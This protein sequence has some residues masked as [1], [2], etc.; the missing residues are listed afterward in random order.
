MD[1]LRELHNLSDTELYNKYIEYN[2]N[3]YSSEDP[4]IKDKYKELIQEIRRILDDKELNSEQLKELHSR[5]YLS[6]PDYNN[7]EFNTDISRKLEFNINK[8][9]FNQQTTCGKQNFELG[10]HQ[11]LLYNFMNKN[12]PYKSLLIFHG[13]GVGKTCTA[14]KISESFRDI[15]TNKNNKIIVLRKGG[16]GQGWKNTIFDPNLGENQCSGHEFL[17]HINET[18]GFEKRDDQSIKRDVNK[19]IKKYYD[20]YAYREF[21]NSIDNML[22][23]C[24]K[25]E[26][27]E[28]II[29]KNNF[30]NRLLIVDEY[31]NLRSDESPDESSKGEKEEQKKA[32]KNLLKIVENADNLRL[33]LLTATPMYNTSDEIFNLLNIL[34]L[35]DNRPV[36]NYKQYITD[37]SINPDG[38]DILNRKFRGY[39]SYLRGENPVNF[40]IRIYPTD[41]PKSDK[42]PLGL[43]P[44]D[45]PKMDL[46]GK[47]IDTPMKFLITYDNK[48]HGDQKSAYEEL[49]SKLDDDRKLSIQDSNLKQ[50]CNV[51][52]PSKKN[53]YGKEGFESVFNESKKKF[54]YKKGVQHILEYK[55][56]HNHSIKIKNIIDNIK[57]SEGI[58]FIYSEYI[59]GGSVPVGLAL[60]HIGFNKYDNKNLLN[61]S[62]KGSEKGTY[63]ILS[64][65]ERVS[66]NN[67]EEIK[68]A[69]SEENKD[70]DLIKVIIG[71]SITG[72]GMDFKNIRQIHILDPWWHLSKLEQI[73]GRGIRYCSHIKLPE[74]KRNVTVFLHT[75]T[76]DGKETIDHYSYRLG[77][78]K[79]FEIGKVETILKKNAIDC[80]LFKDT[81]MI[82]DPKN[83]LKVDVKVSRNN[84]KKFK[85]S[86][87]DKPYSKICSYQPKC[88]YECDNIN[89][90][91]LDN[92]QDITDKTDINEYKK[93]MLVS[94]NYK[95][96]TWKG[97]I[98]GEGD[99]KNKVWVTTGK[100]DI[101]VPISKLTILNKIDDDTVNFDYF[102]DIKRN[103]LVY[104]NEL[105]NK[106][107]FFQ[108]HDIIE[109][110]Q[111]KKDIN[112]KIIYNILKNII[113]SKDRIYDEYNNQGYMICKNNI[114]IFQP[115][116]NNDENA[117]IFYRT[118]TGMN[119]KINIDIISGNMK[120]DLDK[121]IKKE[122][123]IKPNVKEISIKIK[124][125]YKEFLKDKILTRF[126]FVKDEY[127]E[128]LFNMCLDE[129]L[130]EEKQVLIKNVITNDHPKVIM[131]PGKL[132][133]EELLYLT[134]E[135]FKNHLIQKDDDERYT[136]FKYDRD[137]LGYIL[138]NKNILE[139]YDMDDNLID[140][141]LIERDLLKS[142]TELDKSEYDKIFNMN[143]LY[144]QPYINYN[145]NV[146]ERG[147]RYTFKFF[148][149]V[150]LGKG[151]IVG[152]DPGYTKTLVKRFMK[153]DISEF[154]YLKENIDEFFDNKTIY[155]EDKFKII[156]L[157]FRIKNIE[158]GRYVISDELNYLRLK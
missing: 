83:L 101:Q 20:F 19:L 79:S 40:P 71:S 44:K 124:E 4:V 129:L 16:L 48:L 1:D 65:D 138:M 12:T 152:N 132:K 53:K 105:Y 92:L 136:L 120:D 125:M 32:L 86:I 123:L 102:K 112:K 142:I 22:E 8:L 64:K 114:Y 63:V 49:I 75:A 140:K 99:K 58:I 29:I 90:K 158:N 67:N 72:E 11:R 135:Y 34:L 150:K 153:L 21:S 84:I 5:E 113:D 41:Y 96:E 151:V 82:K 9:Y 122:P 89:I 156:E 27:K 76:C 108:L 10:N 30:S 14:V 7:P 37:N 80:Y 126:E 2:S 116:F 18:K 33:I 94:F 70:G 121:L 59:L 104:L 60:E 51:Y 157:V 26:E 6:Y 77:E 81:N 117:P 3:I 145:K 154:T 100:K 24:E 103:I 28:R 42:D 149:G 46:F 146:S 47:P 133:R 155:G 13:V 23:N 45:C 107:K 57:G 115:V 43:L 98:K 55:N 61:I 36:I 139:Y 17:D 95:S 35:N 109:Y 106:N 110:I 131:T 73:I 144:I 88:E 130:F 78:S 39:V 128:I 93:G 137:T 74:E 134:Y 148:D 118:T 66:G 141:S 97:T 56:L 85:K 111:Y 54:T 68:V 87:S 69:T 38:I 119:N 62:D 91:E 127:K 15:H 25:D 50:I 143:K 31:H 52:Y 147:F